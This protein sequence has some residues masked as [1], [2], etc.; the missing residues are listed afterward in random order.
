MSDFMLRAVRGEDL[1]DLRFE[2]V[3][4][5]LDRG[6]Q[7]APR[8]LVRTAPDNDA[9]MI[10][11]FP[12]QHLAERTFTLNAAGVLAGL[13]TAGR[14]VPTRIAGPS[15][16]GFRLR[17]DIVS[18]PLTLDAL[19][20]WSQFEPV[21]APAALGRG[22]IVPPGV[23]ETV[24]EMPFRL[25]LSPDQSAKWV[26]AT[27]RPASDGA[28]PLWQTR[29]E[30]STGGGAVPVRAI[31]AIPGSNPMVLSLSA[32]NRSEIVALSSD[33]ALLDRNRFHEELL[34]EEDIATLE[35]LAPHVARPMAAHVVALSALGGSLRVT[36]HFDFPP[37]GNALLRKRIG[38]TAEGDD[39]FALAEWSQDVSLGRDQCVRV[40]E[41]GYLFPLQH[42]AAIVK[43]VERRFR[44]RTEP[45]GEPLPEAERPAYLVR[46]EYLVLQELERDY[47]HHDL[48]FTRIRM[49]RRDTPRLDPH[50]ESG[51]FVPSVNGQPYRFP[52]MA[53][54]REGRDLELAMGAVFVPGG[55]VGGLVRVANL[56]RA[57]PGLGAVR[58]GGHL[59]F[60]D[61]AP[62]PAGLPGPATLM[63]HAIELDAAATPGAVP[64]FRPSVSGA[65]V[66]LPGIDRLGG[67]A[68]AADGI[69]IRYHE[70][71][72]AA[73]LGGTSGGVFAMIEGGLPLSFPGET[74]GG[75]VAPAME[76]SGL[77][78]EL[79]AIAN[80]AAVAENP[81]T[82]ANPQALSGLA[83][84]K[85]LGVIPLD[86]LIRAA[87]SRAELPQLVT[88]RVEGGHETQFEWK[89]ALS[90]QLPDP[91]VGTASTLWMKAVL[92]APLT[93]SSDRGPN[94]RSPTNE[95]RASADVDGT[96]TNFALKFGDALTLE[97]E[98]LHFH[99]A[100]G[101]MPVFDPK[102]SGFSFGGA[103]AWVQGL[104]DAL[105][106]F[107]GSGPSIA[108]AP[109]HIAASLRV[110]IPDA[111]LGVLAVQNIAFSTR[112]LLHFADKPA[113]LEFAL[114]SKA[115]PFLL[116]YSVFG[117]GGYVVVRATTGS[118]RDGT[119]QGLSL[120]AG[121]EFGAVVALNLFI[122]KGQAHAMSGISITLGGAKSAL[123]GHV[124]I[125]G[126]LEILA[127]VTISVEF[128][129]S[130][131][132][133][134]VTKVATGRAAVTVMVRVLMF[135]KSVSL[136][137][138]RQLSG[139]NV[140]VVMRTFAET[141]DPED[142]R[143]YCEAFA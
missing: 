50:P 135:A 88:R 34:T 31:F 90:D 24:I 94:R 101:R 100:T 134:F 131:E 119:P 75:I 91:L 19:L 96:L 74:T 12:P 99:A 137:V 57:Q 21:L 132:Y 103:L 130:L 80:A 95:R 43:N 143:A 36:S 27:A 49:I 9:L 87:T 81:E 76:L 26:H 142:W 56:Y 125:F 54:D 141:V 79:G 139:E 61:A 17:R 41:R 3:N 122:A 84:A 59:T 112:V 22:G 51:P 110:P 86:S 104:K 11:H 1:L 65:T 25:I 66:T 69:T 23:H 114:S 16:L 67:V 47:D 20:D 40:V 68:R 113:E 10:V 8:R 7:G 30:G 70:R 55:D 39:L 107:L 77:S 13:S 38:H 126:A 48:P 118:A 78:T 46:E 140:P 2:F 106:P 121:I 28:V 98:R 14:D 37:L 116:S 32:F 117:G 33:A 82:F 64:P 5:T 35:R 15:R 111:T 109:D 124:R 127:L 4:L 128:Y 92:F 58:V 138:E 62:T 102:I 42:R 29:L 53:T 105:T 133:N 136:T 93:L 63:T 120:E 73:G 85:L 52:V 72:A 129:L 44:S 123:S 83:G 18:L 97:F 89:P 6:E 60:V 45:P 115:K 108:I 71:F